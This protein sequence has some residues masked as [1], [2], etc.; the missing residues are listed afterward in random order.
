MNLQN[1][2]RPTVSFAL[3]HC[4]TLV[5]SWLASLAA[6]NIGISL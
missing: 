6:E 5:I 1:Y 3:G 4:D 2:D